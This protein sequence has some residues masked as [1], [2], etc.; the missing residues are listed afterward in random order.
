MRGYTGS[1]DPF[2]E[3]NARWIVRVLAERRNALEAMRFIQ[4][5]CSVLAI[6]GFEPQ[7]GKPE[8]PCVPLQ[9]IQYR[10]REPA[11]ATTV[12]DE[13][14]SDFGGL[15]VDWPQSAARHRRA[16]HEADEIDPSVWRWCIGW[17]GAVGWVKLRI[18]PTRLDRCLPQKRKRRAPLR[19]HLLDDE[20]RWHWWDSNV[21]PER[22]ARGRE[23]AFG[24]SGRGRG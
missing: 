18:Q 10:P 4:R 7:D 22:R 24:T 16:T 1:A 21:R 15:R 3:A 12:L 17:P 5:H 19:I 8:G 13:H 9:G 23:A 20:I 2:L 14:S 11:T 6:A